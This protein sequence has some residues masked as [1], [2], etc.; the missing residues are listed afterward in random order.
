MA[1]FFLRYKLKAKCINDIEQ[2]LD[3]GDVVLLSGEAGK[4]GM[5]SSCEADLTPEYNEEQRWHTLQLISTLWTIL[6]SKFCYCLL[7]VDMCMN[8][9]I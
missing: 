1:R 4:D 6:L 9:I 5:W 2:D 7:T 8:H 3:T